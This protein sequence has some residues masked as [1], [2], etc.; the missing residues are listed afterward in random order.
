MARVAVVTPPSPRFANIDRQAAG[1]MGLWSP[2]RRP[3]VGH[4]KYTQYDLSLLW[5]AGVLLDQGHDV[6]F[7]DGQAERL[8][9]EALARRVSEARPDVIVGMVQFV[10]LV[11]DLRLL[12]SIKRSCPGAR[13]IVVGSIA[14]ILTEEVLAEPAVDFVVASEPELATRDLIAAL[15][16]GED[17]TSVAGIAWRDDGTVR[18]SAPRGPTNLA[19][20]PAAPY[21]LLSPYRYIDRFYFR[22]D[23]IGL[24]T[25]T[26]G[27]PYK[28][29][30]YCPYPAAY[31]KKIRYRNPEVVV[32]EIEF[33]NR[34]YG[35]RSFYFRDQVFTV[36]E[37]H[38]RE[39]CKRIIAA[40]LSIRWICETR[41]DLLRSDDLLDDMRDAGCIQIHFGLESGDPKIFETIGKP[42]TNLVVAEETCQRVVGRGIRVH[43]HLIVGLPGETWATVRNTA[44]FIRRLGVSRI[45]LNRCIPYPGTALYDEAR[46]KGWIKTY[47]WSRYGNEFVMRTADMTMAELGL[48]W[49]YLF[50]KC[51]EGGRGRRLG[52]RDR[53][54]RPALNALVEIVL[55]RTA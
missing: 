40:N 7:V 49:K 10:S 6:C 46:G 5:T 52:R 20:L 53:L 15:T 33:L 38:A 50:L 16:N 19:S 37:R 54:I 18:R 3:T 21:H 28:C 30:Y 32:K 2:T 31:G 17:P 35:I 47:D 41:F 8:N 27:C 51:W 39:I 42:G 14:Q 44:E 9:E 55:Q 43:F 12:A 1:G 13:L 29:A 23:K 4:S 45:N 22:P 24:I 11:S 48:A 26:R 25:T 36:S 34:E